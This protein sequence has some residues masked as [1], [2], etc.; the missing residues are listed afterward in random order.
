MGGGG[1]GPRAAPHP[2][3]ASGLLPEGAG[4]SSMFCEPVGTGLRPRACPQLAAQRGRVKLA[5]AELGAPTRG[6]CL[7]AFSSLNQ[8]RLDQK[9]QGSYPSHAAPPTLGLGSL[10]VPD[11]EGR[12]TSARPARDS[13]SRLG[14]GPR[15]DGAASGPGG[16]LGGA[17]AGTH[18]GLGEAPEGCSGADLGTETRRPKW[19]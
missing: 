15:Q 12:Q 4:F 5:G 10:K 11:W 19:A 13:V 16:H 14:V 2:T 18:G 7:L 8:G 17:L 3:P 1:R 9:P 6:S